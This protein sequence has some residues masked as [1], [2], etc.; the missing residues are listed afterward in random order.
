MDRSVCFAIYLGRSLTSAARLP[1]SI[2]A[3]R[4]TT[5]PAARKPQS[6]SVF[7]VLGIRNY[8]LFFT[9]QLI[10][11]IGGW[12][13]RIAQDWLV[14]S[15]T[16]SATA[17]GITTA[18]QFLP[19]LLFGPYA[20]TLADRFS[21]RSILL[22]TQTVMC[23]CAVIL[24]LSVLTGHVSVT[25]IFA[26]AAVL[27]M[28]TSV[29]NPTRQAFVSE[30]VGPAHLRNAISLNSTAFQ[31]GALIGPAVSGVLISAVGIGWAFAVNAASFLG[32]LGGLL[33]MRK[34]EL[35]PAPARAT[36]RG[37]VRAAAQHV[38]RHPEMW[39]T[40]V[41]AATFSLFT[42]SFPVTLAA[43]ANSVFRTGP[44][45]FALLSGLLAFGSVLGSLCAAQMRKLRLRL[46]FTFGL[47]VALAQLLAALTPGGVTFGVVLVLVGMSSVMFGISA[48]AT[49]QMASADQMRGRVMGIFLLGTIGG[50]CVGGPLVGFLDQHAGPRLALLVGAVLPSLMLLIVAR[51][52]TKRGP[53]GIGEIVRSTAHSAGR[54]AG[55]W[56]LALHRG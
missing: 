29:D 24:A 28:A 1:Q 20:G 4:S 6:G 13:Q 40:I 15:L 12:T 39:S 33:A 27:G 53:E 26:L 35:N 19:T 38:R 41:L 37:Q 16:G 25:E 2:P 31:L 23:C 42:T 49:V 48:N 50:G 7:K 30:M 5:A 9:G 10:S 17:V 52:L 18:L 45:G 56:S 44:S 55:N 8:R 36:G 11:N 32:A 43:F 46:L 14:L 21:K 34:A 51:R 3:F 22:V 47:G 54:R